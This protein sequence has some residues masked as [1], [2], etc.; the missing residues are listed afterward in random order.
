MNVYG[1]HIATV[2]HE[3]GDAELVGV[4]AALRDG[5]ASEPLIAAA[6]PVRAQ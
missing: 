3:A 4:P 5:A 2:V 6:P 1:R